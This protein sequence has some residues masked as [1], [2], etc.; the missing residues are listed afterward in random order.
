MMSPMIRSAAVLAVLWGLALPAPRAAD[1]QSAWTTVTAR[2]GSFTI[3]MPV[4]PS[5]E[6]ERARTGRGRGYTR[7]NYVAEEE[8]RA[9][10]VQVATYPSDV[11]LS[12][13]K[14]TL[15]AGLGNAAD[16]MEGGKWSEVRW[17]SY[18]SEP[19]IEAIATRP[20]FQVRNFSVIKGRTLF[21]LT[22][23]GPPNTAQSADVNRFFS[24]LVV[25]P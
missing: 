1:A 21:T 3:E 14:A 4:E 17:V 25:S 13:R 10:L 8:G 18:Q 15:Q 24:S 11:D 5:Y 20:P 22:Y 2:D 7:H 23:V 12:D 6:T 9:F 16:Q 19:A